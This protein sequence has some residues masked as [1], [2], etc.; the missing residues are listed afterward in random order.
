MFTTVEF[1]STCVIVLLLARYRVDK[2]AHS[3]SDLGLKGS[4]GEHGDVMQTLVNLLVTPQ[5]FNR[6]YQKTTSIRLLTVVLD[7]Y[8]PMCQ[9]SYALRPREAPIAGDDF[10]SIQVS[11][12][13]S[14]R[15]ASQERLT[16]WILNTQESEQT[17]PCQA[18]STVL[19]KERCERR[20]C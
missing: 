12:H 8:M 5:Q 16:M 3:R 13:S 20:S 2:R 15:T 19:S 18:T 9:F 14:V 4:R 6:I 17:L 1:L 10:L 11:N 7:N